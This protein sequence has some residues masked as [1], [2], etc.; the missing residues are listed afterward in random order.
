MNFYKRIVDGVHS[1][2]NEDF[3]KFRIR[4]PAPELIG[5]HRRC[6]LATIAPRRTQAV[7]KVAVNEENHSRIAL[8]TR[9][10]M[11]NHSLVQPDDAVAVTA[12]RIPVDRQAR[13]VELLDVV[14]RTEQLNLRL[15]TQSLP[16]E[17]TE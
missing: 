11:P 14:V 17:L 5:I 4:N 9:R 10:P 13:V 16:V 7:I 2:G 6:K 8:E 15:W 12:E 3:G 1:R